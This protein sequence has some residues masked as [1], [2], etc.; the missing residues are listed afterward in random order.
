MSE[1]EDDNNAF[2]TSQTDTATICLNGMIAQFG[3]TLAKRVLIPE[4]QK[5]NEPP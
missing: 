2:D 4:L 5:E 1:A 3:L